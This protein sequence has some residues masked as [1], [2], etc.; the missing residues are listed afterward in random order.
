MLFCTGLAG[1]AENLIIR[2]IWIVLAALSLV[3]V[4]LS[5]KATKTE[6]THQTP[7]EN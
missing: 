1:L 5:W 7:P 6:Q 3:F 4:I 2:L